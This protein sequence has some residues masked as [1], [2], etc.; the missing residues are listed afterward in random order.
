MEEF[1]MATLVLPQNHTVIEQEEMMY[2]DGGMTFTRQQSR[3]ALKALG[4]ATP[5]LAISAAL[6]AVVV[7]RV[8]RWAGVKGGVVG[9]IIGWAAGMVTKSIGQILWGLGQGALG[10]GVRFRWNLTPWSLISATRL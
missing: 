1:I 2:L 3:T 4:F 8:K 10:N 5:Q 6:T 9:M 7:A